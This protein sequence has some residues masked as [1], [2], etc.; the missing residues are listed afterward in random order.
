MG[1]RGIAVPSSDDSQHLD[2]EKLVKSRAQDAVVGLLSQRFAHAHR[3]PGIS[4]ISGKAHSL[5]LD[6]VTR[7]APRLTTLRAFASDATRS[8]AGIVDVLTDSA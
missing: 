5:R 1:F 8:C 7:A 2:L 3:T 4:Q 6:Q